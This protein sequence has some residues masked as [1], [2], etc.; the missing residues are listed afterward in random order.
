MGLKVRAT[1]R[2]KNLLPWVRCGLTA[3][4]NSIVAIT[5]ISITRVPVVDIRCEPIPVKIGRTPE[6]SGKKPVLLEKDRSVENSALFAAKVASGEKPTLLAAKIPSGEKPVL[7]TAK[8]RKWEAPAIPGLRNGVRWF[9]DGQRGHRSEK[10]D[11]L[12]HASLL[13][14]SAPRHLTLQAHTLCRK[15]PIGGW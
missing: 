10:C 5:V 14:L 11:A 9:R 13:Y 15:D 4:V 7:L 8:V 3:H 2:F 1:V 12:Q 6:R